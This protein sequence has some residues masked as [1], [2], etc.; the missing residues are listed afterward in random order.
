MYEVLGGARININLML[1]NLGGGTTSVFYSGLIWQKLGEG[2]PPNSY[3]PEVSRNFK[4]SP[5]S[6]SKIRGS[7]TRKLKIF[8]KI[9]CSLEILT[10]NNQKISLYWFSVFETS[11]CIYGW[12]TVCQKPCKLILFGK[13]QCHMMGTYILADEDKF[14]NIVKFWR[15]YK[16]RHYSQVPNRQERL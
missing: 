7:L 12:H 10:L 3:G 16:V 11:C 8:L 2:H 14:I 13:Q 9:Y 15:C 1:E 4:P 5:W 6:E